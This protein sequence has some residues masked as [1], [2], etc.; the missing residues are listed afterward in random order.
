MQ[1]QPTEKTRRTHTMTQCG[2][3]PEREE[4]TFFTSSVVDGSAVG[5]GIGHWVPVGFVVFLSD[6][7]NFV[8]AA[9]NYRKRCQNKSEGL[10]AGDKMP[11][12]I[13]VRTD[14]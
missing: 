13:V 9:W 7:V 4:N 11:L 8:K 1:H 2:N 3:N 5:A 12:G 14:R 6:K 10:A